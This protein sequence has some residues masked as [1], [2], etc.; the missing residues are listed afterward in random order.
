[1]R[2]RQKSGRYVK[3]VLYVLVIVLV[4]IAG[5]T[6]FKRFDL[7]ANKVYSLSEASKRVVAGLSEPL[8][9]N[10]FFTE[11]L[12]APHNNTARYLKDLLEEYA[13]FS[14]QYFNF[15]FFNV[16]AEEGDLSADAK[17]NQELANNYG[18]HPLQI[19]AIDKD[20]VKFQ[21]AYMGLVMIHGDLIERIQAITTTDGLEYRL[22]TAIQKMTNKISA[23]MALSGDIKATLYMSPSLETVAPFMGIRTMAQLPEQIEATVAELGKKNYNRLKF[24][25]IS[26]PDDRAAEKIAS[27]FNLLMLSWPDLSNGKIPAGKGMIGLVLEYGDRAASIPLLQVLRLPLIGTQY[28]LTEKEKVVENVNDAIDSLININADIG[29]LADFGSL[30]ISNVPP[31]MPGMPQNQ[32]ALNNFQQLVSQ[33]YTLRNVRLGEEDLPE[34]LRSLIVAGPRQPLSEYALFQIDQFLMQGNHLVLFL[35]RFDEKMPGGQAA[36]FQ[37]RQPQYQ[38]IDT[39]LEKLLDHY[40]VRIKSSYVLDESC[41]RQQ[42]PQRLGGGE[43]PIYFAPMIKDQNIYQGFDFLNNIKALVTLKVSPLELDT[44]RINAQKI[45]A[46]ELLASSDRAWEMRG[47]INLNPLFIRPPS[48]SDQFGRLPLAYLLEGEFSSYFAGKPIPVREIKEERPQKE[49]GEPAQETQPPAAELSKIERRGE[50]LEKGR[51]GKIFIMASAEMLKDNVLDAD[52]RGTN[53]MFVLNTIDY[54]NDNEDIAVM[55]S[56]EQRFNPL[57]ETEAGTKTFAKTFNVIGLPALASV[58]GLLVWLRRSSRKKRIQMM[59]DK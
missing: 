22:T 54:L 26:P 14:N 27:K 6:L 53:A 13:A 30:Q 19:Q 33:N 49:E 31:G 35:D 17:E 1:M 15:R 42:V 9:I 38:P 25:Y 57:R 11:N 2:S 45:Q 44:E 40:G 20:E 43:R 5:I 24:E 55:R 29:Y 36:Q 3:F 50:F 7:T 51:P 4:N 21:R 39:G 23:L 58:F 47:R 56:K 18:I 41:F 10:V 34:G 8:T 52:G 12:P 32:S 28:K 16:S 59:F 48:E 46:Y 37:P